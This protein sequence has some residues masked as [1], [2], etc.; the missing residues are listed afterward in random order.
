MDSCKLVFNG[1]PRFALRCLFALNERRNCR[2]ASLAPERL[3]FRPA[4]RRSSFTQQSRQWRVFVTLT[5]DIK[6]NREVLS[7]PCEYWT[8]RL[9][10]M[11]EFEPRSSLKI[12]SSAKRSKSLFN[13]LEHISKDKKDINA[14]FNTISEHTR[15]LCLPLMFHTRTIFLETKNHQRTNVKTSSRNG[16]VLLV[17]LFAILHS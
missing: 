16:C 3:L 15:K 9:N 11:I 12:M 7:Q 6:G 5:I 13:V 2:E 17:Y 14:I 4:T 8:G 10:R 1:T